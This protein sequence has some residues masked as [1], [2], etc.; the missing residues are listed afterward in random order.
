MTRNIATCIT[1]TTCN[2][3]GLNVDNDCYLDDNP[4]LCTVDRR[5]DRWCTR[6]ELAVEA[7][8]PE[9]PDMTLEVAIQASL[10]HA[11]VPCTPAFMVVP[12]SE[13]PW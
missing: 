9:P 6:D 7:E 11:E 2:V 4:P 12:T 8:L 3:H 5:M 1:S 10:H 13:A